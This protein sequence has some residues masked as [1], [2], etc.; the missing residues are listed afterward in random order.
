MLALLPA[1]VT[2]GGWQLATWVYGHFGCEGN[3][4]NLQPCFAGSVNLLPWLGI[5]LFWLQLA[6]WVAVPVSAWLFIMTAAR[7]IGS[8]N[9]VSET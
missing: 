5:G 7:H 3:L 9:N 6:T 8:R 2:V 1:F 4:K